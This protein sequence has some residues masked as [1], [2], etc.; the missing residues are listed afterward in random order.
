MRTIQSGSTPTLV[1][2]PLRDRLQT[3]HDLRTRLRHLLAAGG[4][5]ATRTV[6]EVLR[7]RGG[8]VGRGG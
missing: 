4:D 2:R 3:R 8:R 6:T 5:S 7:L 1:Q